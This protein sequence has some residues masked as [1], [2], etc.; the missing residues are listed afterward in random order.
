MTKIKVNYDSSKSD[1]MTIQRFMG[2]LQSDGHICFGF[3]K[4][5]TFVLGG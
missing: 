2:F 3:D 5:K 1:G 4:D